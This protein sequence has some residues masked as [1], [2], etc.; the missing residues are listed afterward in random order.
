MRRQV[1]GWIERYQR[2]RTAEVAEVDALAAWL[3]SELPDSPAPTMIHND[4]KLNN[5]LLDQHNPRHMTAVLDWEMATVGDPLSD[6]ASLVVYWTQPGEADLMG[7]LRSVTMEPG[8]A[9]REEIVDLYARLS[10]RDLSA[11]PWYVAFAYFKVGAICQQIYYRWFK[12]QT[13]DERFSG[14]GAVAANLILKAAS[15][16]ALT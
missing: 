5:V 9:S 4:Y 12:G 1:G 6:L 8:F 14:L 13:H 2:V 16:A 3:S 15:V 7:G 10:R 11:L